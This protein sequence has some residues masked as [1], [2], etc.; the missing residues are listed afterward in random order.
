MKLLAGIALLGLAIASSLTWDP[1]PIINE[2]RFLVGRE[3]RYLF[4]GQVTTGLSL[5]DTQQSATRLQA[6]VT[7]QPIDERL[8]VLQLTQVRLG[9]IQEEF[10]PRMLLPFE[11]FQLVKLDKEHMEMLMLP[12]RFVYKHGMISDIEF[13]HEDMPWS[14][15]IKKAVLNMLQINLL[16]RDE[17]MK[18]ERDVEVDNKNFFSAIERTLEGECE[19]EYTT[20]DMKEQ[21][22]Q[23]TKS[24]NFQKCN[25]R[26]E[27]H[28]GIRPREMKNVVDEKLFS[29]VFKYK[30]AGN[31]DEFLIHDVE[32]ESQYKLASLSKK[33]ELITSFVYNKMTLV[34]AGKTETTIPK[35]R[36]DRKESLIYNFEWEL[37]EEKFAMTGDEKYLT[38]IPEWKNKM[39]HIEKLLTTMIRHTDEKIELETT[40][41]FARLVKLLRLCREQELVKIQHF[42]ENHENVNHKILSLYYDALAM[43]GT[44]VT[45]TE[46]MNK[47]ME[48]KVDALKAARLMKS[49]S[50]IRVPSEKIANEILRVCESDVAE[51]KLYLKQSCWLTYGAI[52]NG[53][54]HN[55]KLAVYQV[56]NVCKRELKERVVRKLIDMM[57]RV[58][59]R[60]E[61]VLMLKTLGNAGIDISVH[62]LEK[63]IY[64]KEEEKVIRI[65]AI[66]ALRKLRF[67]MPRKIQSI[68]M[69]IYKDRTVIS[70]I[71]MVALRRIL[72]TKPEQMII[73]QI[74]RQ[75]EVER[76]QHLRAFTYRT[77]KT[78]SEF[79]EVH[80][81]TVYM[82]KK[83][84]RTIDVDFYENLYK[85]VYRYTLKNVDHKYGVLF[86]MHS[87]ITKDSI[88][89][90]E[91]L[92][93]LDTIFGGEWYKHF[94][95][96][97]F[98]Q[99][100]IDEILNKLL[101]K[102]Q[103]SDM[104]HLVVRGKRS[105]IY[106]PAELFRSIYE[107]LNF[108]R[109][110]PVKDDAHAMIY[111]RYMD[112][113]YAFLPIDVDTIPKYIKDMFHDGKI[114]LDEIERFLA[115][116]THFTKTGGFFVYEYVR[117]IPT[118]LGLPI[119][120]TSKMPTVAT[121]QGHIK[122]EM[123]P[124]ESR[125]FDGLRLRLL[126]KPKIA[127]THVVKVV[128]MSP[129][130]ENGFKMLHSA[131]FDHPIETETVLTWKH[132]LQLKT[133]FRPL[134]HKT[135]VLHLQSRPVTF[136]RH[137]K[138]THNYPEPIENTVHLNK[139][140]YPVKTYEHTFL[141]RYGTMVKLISTLHH[142][143]VRE[144]MFMLNPIF[145]GYNTY[146]LLLEPTDDVP[147]EIVF[148]MELET[149][150]PERMEKPDINKLLKHHDDMFTVNVEEFEPKRV[151]DRKT[152][153]ATYLRDYDIEKGFKHRL[154]FKI[155]T[156]GQ[157]EKH[158]AEMELKVLC[159]NKYRFCHTNFL[160]RR[161]PFEKETR[162]WEMKV[163][164][165]TVYPEMPKTLTQ[166]KE[167][168]HREVLGVIDVMW[169]NEH[170][171]NM[172]IRIQGEQSRE[173]KMWMKKLDRVENKLSEMEK[174]KIF[175]KLNLYKML[176]KYDL[177]PE[178]EY[179][180]HKMFS[181]LKTWNMWHTEFENVHNENKVLRIQF[182][183]E[184]LYRRMFDL[185]IETPTERVV[186]KKLNMPMRLPT[187]NIHDKYMYDMEITGL[188]DVVHHV[189]K[190]NR[191]ECVVKS[192]EVNTFD[193]LFFKTPLSTCYTVLA[194]DC[195]SEEP[196][197]VVLMKKIR[198]DGEEKKLKIVTRDDVYVV[199]MVDEKLVVKVNDK[200]IKTE[201]FKRY[202]II[203]MDELL[204][205]IDVND[206]VVMFDGFE[207]NIKLSHLFKNKQCGVCGHYDGEKWNDLRRADDIETT[208]IEDF[209]RSYI[210]KDNDCEVDE[211][212]MT[213]KFNH[214][215]EKDLK[216][217]NYRYREEKEM[218]NEH[219][220]HHRMMYED[221]EEYKKEIKPILRTRI[222]ERRNL[223]CFSV[224]PVYECPV[225]TTK[226]KVEEEEIEFVCKRDT[227]EVRRLMRKAREEILLV[228]DMELDGETWTNTIHVPKMCTVY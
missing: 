154:F 27:V 107:K 63:I 73:D 220:H 217:H 204:Y 7:L 111:F 57:K 202:G 123:E 174:L 210:T 133:I 36:H 38:H 88:L 227:P 189:V 130:V 186:M 44:K 5:P 203:K 43:A 197:F 145:V 74:V 121:V 126:V 134:E 171:N 167:Q 226:H 119:V 188:K 141:K 115:T 138:K 46:L 163:N 218:I 152:H 23:W 102:L 225:H 201:D 175:S 66:H 104:E 194:K 142:P 135:N 176:V 206:V 85:T 96:L 177:T 125:V 84:L 30:V 205:K 153:I 47:I 4:D 162:D 12:I 87:L 24:I 109:R 156:V 6:I 216:H 68:L 140:L 132:K 222:I 103:E 181:M 122:V 219:K 53:L 212:E 106:H 178:V 34:Y 70:E 157:R 161:T 39:E 95:Q 184:P 83:A 120:F 192:Y 97:G 131:E 190:R 10:E 56:E 71:R 65:E 29:T 168:L 198:K 136:I 3:Y 18:V 15:N 41:L 52:F 48:E 196:R 58:E 89:P 21:F 149:F 94:L 209:H 92:T 40:H 69:P 28:Y 211:T 199:E 8:T 195:T 151:G 101:H 51:R 11:R 137:M 79:P 117:K 67:I 158:E 146:D 59:T 72:E 214:H 17:T 193:N 90:K 19:V 76:D 54:C 9:S 55:D 108:V 166:L 62:E 187:V 35:V 16:K 77:L 228:K 1:K 183:I 37:N 99:Q 148:H 169:G 110:H 179:K 81:K 80:E 143:I 213:K 173:Q 223:V 170:K 50:E 42:L 60:Y 91:L 182:E 224:E 191:A 147:K 221:E 78:I 64:D 128:V 26:P 139:V 113:D 32:L 2:D 82:V 124:K 114:D 112:M 49:L 33:H 45:V 155:E 144:D 25:I 180:M 118:T 105:S 129:I 150:V 14:I 215:L 127:S 200:L 20:T 207:V 208:E 172:F 22:V 164:M 185:L 31:K 86:D 93:S 61:K 75:M 165:Q 13:T 160:A 116:G 98:S 159:D 100:N